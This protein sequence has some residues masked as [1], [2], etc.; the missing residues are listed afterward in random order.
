MVETRGG[1]G[2]KE[3]GMEDIDI[4]TRED[5]IARRTKLIQTTATPTMNLLPSQ[6]IK[7]R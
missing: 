2:G 7:C 4:K 3:D 6:Y 5:I 1:G